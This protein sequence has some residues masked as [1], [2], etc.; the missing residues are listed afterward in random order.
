M[1]GCIVD[2]LVAP[3][4]FSNL[5]SNRSFYK[6]ASELELLVNRNYHW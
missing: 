6:F 2:R 4:I 1:L 3:D 5:L